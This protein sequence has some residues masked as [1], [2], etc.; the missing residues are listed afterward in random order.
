MRSSERTYV[1]WRLTLA[2]NRRFTW[3]PF[4]DAPV[5]KRSRINIG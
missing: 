1:Q 5:V 3:E 2:A 4:R